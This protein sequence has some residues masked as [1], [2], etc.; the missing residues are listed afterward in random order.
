[1]RLLLFNFTV[2]DPAEKKV[3]DKTVY[4]SSEQIIKWPEVYM[5]NGVDTSKT[6]KVKQK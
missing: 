4:V 5:D 6:A 1:M 3:S 2:N